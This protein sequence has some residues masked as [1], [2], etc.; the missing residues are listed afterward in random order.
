MEIPVYL[1]TGFLES[2]K[3]KFIQET[4]EDKKFNNAEKTLLLLCEEGEEEYEPSRFNCKN[5]VIRNIDE[6]EDISLVAL[7]RLEKETGCDRVLIEYNGMW[8]LPHLY[9]Q[10]PDNWTVYQEVMFA[11][12]TTI[13]QYNANMR[14]LVV[15]KLNNCELVVFNRADDDNVKPELHKLVRGI[16]RRAEILYE[17]TKGVV[18]IDEIEDPLPFDINADVIE[19]EDKDYALWY[20]DLVEDF[21]KYD[22]KTV[23]F[24]GIVAKDDKMPENTA[25]SGR[26]I[27]TCCV[28]DIEYRGLVCIGDEV[29]KLKLRDWITVV[30]KIKVEKHKIYRG[31]GPVLYVKEIE[32]S[33]K[34]EQEVATFY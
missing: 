17:S 7:K 29:E 19:I 12:A 15:D 34:P 22:G 26:H 6:K 27:M 24:K 25:I 20:R 21:K 4:L 14:S 2:G 13:L 1:F 32:Y 16:S 11:D 5:V 28:D 33:E 31:K 23:K 18:E 30:A 3:T 10:M 8:D 9:T